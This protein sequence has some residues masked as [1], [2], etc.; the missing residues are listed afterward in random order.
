VQADFSPVYPPQ[1]ADIS[2]GIPGHRVEQSLLPPDA[3]A[4]ALVPQDD[5]LEPIASRPGIQRPW[6]TLTWDDS[7]WLEGHIGVGYDYPG[8]IG[9]DVGAMRHTNETVYIRIPFWV[10]D[11]SALVSLTLRLRFEDGMIAYINGY[12]VASDPWP[13]TGYRDL[14]FWGQ[15]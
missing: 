5:S 12:E 13:R 15:R 3:P 7:S 8:L 9:L 2:Y 10:E 11:P 1:A 14:E 6:T 4:R